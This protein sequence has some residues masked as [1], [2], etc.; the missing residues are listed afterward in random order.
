MFIASL[1]DTGSVTE[2]ASDAGMSPRSAYQ[3][4]RSAGA[5]S[6]ARAW[7]LAIVQATRMLTDVA[8]ERAINGVSEPVFDR[9]GTMTG[10]RRKYNDRLLMFL[11]RHH[12]R[13]VYGIGAERVLSMTDRAAAEKW[14][15]GQSPIPGALDAL[16]DR[17]RPVEDEYYNFFGN[18]SSPADME[19]MR[20]E[21]WGGERSDRNGDCESGGGASSG[22]ASSADE[23]GADNRADDDTGELPADLIE[24]FARNWTIYDGRRTD[25]DAAQQQADDADRDGD[26]YGEYD[27][28]EDDADHDDADYDEDGAY[29]E[30]GGDGPDGVGNVLHQSDENGAVAAFLGAKQCEAKPAERGLDSGRSDPFA[31]AD[32]TG[33]ASSAD[34]DA[35]SG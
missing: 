11:L 28:Y 5:E 15:A 26:E 30:D 10:V 29:D 3:L 16:E 33:P 27:D 19:A 21:E 8:L 35:Q 17:Q 12:R 32:R 14:D 22:G 23:S 4:R 13:G 1:A 9:D 34:P 2:A 20:R 25:A 24:A 18:S 31:A 6:F 7:D